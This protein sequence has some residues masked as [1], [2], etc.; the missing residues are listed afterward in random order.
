MEIYGWI[1]TL[2]FCLVKHGICAKPSTKR[3]R[4]LADR[5]GVLNATRLS[6]I[7]HNGS[8]P[9]RWMASFCLSNY[10]HRFRL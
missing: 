7:R 5:S 9:Q 3:R 2:I 6:P 4:H 10:S 1:K 8:R